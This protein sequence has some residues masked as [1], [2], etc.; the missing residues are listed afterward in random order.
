MINF[1]QLQVVAWIVLLAGL[2]CLCHS[3]SPSESIT[4][5]NTFSSRFC[6]ILLTSSSIT[7]HLICVYLLANCGS[8]QNHDLYL[9]VLS[10]LK[11]FIDT[12]VFDKPIITGD[13]KVNFMHPSITGDYLHTLMND[14]QLCA[15]DLLLCF[16][17]G[18]TYERDDGLVRYVLTNCH[19]IN[20]ISYILQTIF[21]IMYCYFWNVHCL[22]CIYAAVTLLA[23]LTTPTPIITLT[24]VGLI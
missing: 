14:L 10:E 20:D 9:E 17:I 12:Q 24:G 11:G 19:C 3:L 22:S 16:S 21:L 5:I 6:A 7:F 15:V 23:R 2:W 18:F 1:P 4:T 13:F 8:S